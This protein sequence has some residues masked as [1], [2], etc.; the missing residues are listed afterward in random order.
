LQ[1]RLAVRFADGVEI[2]VTDWIFEYE[3]G[4]SDQTVQGFSFCTP[5]YHRTQDL[6]LLFTT[7]ERGVT[8]RNQRRI[9]P[10][11]L[12]S[13]KFLYGKDIFSDFSLKKVVIQPLN[14]E[15]IEVDQLLPAIGLL[16]KAKNIFEEKLYLKG[17]AIISNQRG[18]FSKKL[19]RMHEEKD[20]KERIAEI[21]F[22]K[23]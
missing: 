13:I 22:V 9:S 11:Q 3:Y 20:I 8:Y 2:E 23:K 19:Y 12:R 10:T 6:I 1:T 17:T 5:T 7:T 16:T 21:N 4:T 15:I 18:E 14:A